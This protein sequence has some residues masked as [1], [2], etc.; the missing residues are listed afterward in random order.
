MLK[1]AL[2]D[3]EIDQLSITANIINEYL[4]S[5]KTA[6]KVCQF[7]SPVE[8]INELWE[9][10]S[11]D[12]YIL[13]IVMSDMDGIALGKEIRKI[14]KDAI[15][16]YLTT[17]P[18][19]AIESYDTRAFYYMLK[20][21]D[22]AKFFDVFGEAVSFF[23]KHRNDGVNVK[24]KNGMARLLFDDILY[25]ELKD[26]SVRYCLKDGQSIYSLTLTTSFKEAVSPLM[27]DD[28]FFLCGASFIVNLYYVM[29]VDKSGAVLSD[30]SRLDLP[31]ASCA[32]LR[33][34]WS[35]YWL[36]KGGR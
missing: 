1:I 6:A 14:D 22:K 13:D 2:C 32:S 8:L 18:D 26:R 3:D 4:E 24:T 31:K 30:E 34:A 16:I 20:P 15:L 21:V 27:A 9:K 36:E 23:V 19:F 29:M 12:I 35:D 5:N 25:A 17:S 33:T 11:F 10:K 28:R 7:V